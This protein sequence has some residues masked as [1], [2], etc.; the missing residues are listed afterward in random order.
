[1]G[2]AL[3][4][5]ALAGLL[6]VA[7]LSRTADAQGRVAR[8][9]TAAETGE[10]AKVQKINSWTIGLAGGLPE[11][12]F[13]RFG[14]EIARNLNDPEELRVLPVIT[15]GA[16][17]NV[18]DLLYLRGI[19]VAIT[20]ADV[21]DYF[22]NQERIPNIERRIN[23]ISEMVISEVHLVVRP[24]I[25]SIKDLE[26]K[27]VSL[28]AKGA[29][30]ST[31][32]PIVFKRLGVNPEFVYVNNAIALEKMK[33]GEIDALVNNG[34]KPQDLFTKFNNADAGFK[35]LPIPIDRF[36]E[37]YIPATLTDQDYPQFIKPGEKVETLGVQTVLAVYN[38]PRESDRYRR[39]QRFIERYFDMFEKFH[40]PPY[41]PKWK[42]VNLAA[43]VPGWI[44]YTVAEEKLK[45][46]EAAKAPAPIE[47]SRASPPKA[48][49]TG[50]SDATDQEKLFQQFLE[51]SK[52]Q[53]RR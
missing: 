25:N 48:I 19:D 9:P 39:V 45:Q 49:R 2:E 16:T 42:S 40:V 11:G 38:W 33:T 53:G 28:G 13:I 21:L 27:K 29:G 41:H 37:Y 10:T 17:D 1:M 12:T 22:K 6:I 24:G 4:V 47:T 14:A 18:K 8:A 23:F 35:F 5:S 43:N 15:Q 50:G 26:G 31:T 44:R 32:G 46:M 51:W 34:A 3:A 7:V 30:Q 52:K 36:D 20:N